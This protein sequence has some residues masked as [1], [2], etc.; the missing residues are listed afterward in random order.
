MLVVE[1]LVVEETDTAVVVIIPV[2]LLEVRLTPFVSLEVVVI[3]GGVTIVT[4]DELVVVRRGV[5]VDEVI[6]APEMR[7]TA[8]SVTDRT[9]LVA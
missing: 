4:V 3:T 2:I 7:G 5:V 6:G 1:L 9:Q 8:V